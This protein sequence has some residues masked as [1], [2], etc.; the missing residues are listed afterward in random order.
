MKKFFLNL[1]QK[2]TPESSKRFCGMVGFMAAATV[3]CVFKQQFL[4]ELL[5]T[6]AGLM[7]LGIFDK[8]GGKKV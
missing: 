3:I 1:I 6:S 5:Y 7:G 2:D 4:C 8:I